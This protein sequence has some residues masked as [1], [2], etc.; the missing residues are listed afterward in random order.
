[1]SVRTGSSSGDRRRTRPR[2]GPAS[3][4][5]RQAGR[6]AV[7][8]PRA[9]AAACPAA[10]STSARPAA[11]A[12]SSVASDGWSVRAGR[13][14]SGLVVDVVSWSWCVHGRTSS[15]GRCPRAPP[16]PPARQT[17]RAERAVRSA[18]SGSARPARLRQAAASSA[19]T[20]VS[21]QSRPSLRYSRCTAV[22]QVPH[23][24]TPRVGGREVGRGDGGGADRAAGELER[25]RRRT[26]RS[27][28][29]AR[30]H[31]RAEAAVPQRAAV[32]GVGQR[33]V[34]DHVEPAG[35]RLVDVG[36]QVGGQDGEAVEGLHPLQQVG[37]LDVGVAV[38][39]VPDLRALAEDRVGLVE[40]QHGVDA[41]RRREDPLEVLLGLADVLVDDGGQVDDVQVEAEVARRP[42]RPTS[43]CRCRSR[44]R[45]AP[46]RRC[47][48]PPPG[49]IRQSPSTCSRC[50]ARSATSLQRGRATAGGS[51]RSSQP[52]AARP[53]GRAARAPSRSRRGRRPAGASAVITPVRPTA[54]PAPARTP[55]PGRPASGRSRNC[56]GRLQRVAARAVVP[57]SANRHSCVRSAW[58]LGGHVDEQRRLPASR[59]GPRTCRRRAAAGAGRRRRALEQRR[60][61]APAPP[62]GRRPGRHRLSRASRTASRASRRRVGLRGQPV[63]VEHAA[64]R[65]P[66][67]PE[68]LGGQH[69]PGP[70][71]RLAE[72]DQRDAAAERRGE[73]APG[74]PTGRPGRVPSSRGQ[75]RVRRVVAEQVRARPGRAPAARGPGTAGRAP[76]PP[77]AP[78]RTSGPVEQARVPARGDASGTPHSSSATATDGPAP[79][80]VVVEV[81][82]ELLEPRV[83]VGGER[84]QEQV[85]VE[86]RRGRT[87]RARSRSRS[88]HPAS[89]ASSAARSHAVEPVGGVRPVDGRRLPVE[90]P[91]DRL[92]AE[93]EAPERVVRVRGRPAAVPRRAAGRAPRRRRAG[94]AGA[95]GCGVVDHVLRPPSLAAGAAR[96]WWRVLRRRPPSTPP[97]TMSWTSR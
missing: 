88:R 42:P 25:R 45:T 5:P 17:G 47:P 61:V 68:R 39:R 23:A 9:A 35:E 14:R 13:R 10:P 79:G 60:P 71:R 83:E 78:P 73:R 69:P 30:A 43:S 64:R 56:A 62:P 38:V 40:E 31:R 63:E 81:A 97:S 82:E 27:T 24:T 85:D 4:P 3:A 51:T 52:T 18:R 22:D 6:R 96:R 54:S 59:P 26:S 80:D 91:V 29:S 93:V 87:S 21:R 86:R 16:R 2:R 20:R 53:G 76:R 11:A 1:M 84:D 57:A 46:P 67:Q 55:P 7:A 92:V 66:G 58:V 48:R 34:D 72:V 49:R 70:G 77:P 89:S 95:R 8:R 19:R 12:R 65:V 15:V 36:A 33:E 44:R 41:G 28:S 94:R 37:A 75:R 50:R 90:E 32:R 74:R